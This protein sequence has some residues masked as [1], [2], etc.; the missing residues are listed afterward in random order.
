[1]IPRPS[2]DK[3]RRW[4]LAGLLAGAA[5]AALANAPSAS[6]RP[7]LRPGAARTPVAEDPLAGL[8]PRPRP[9]P[10]KPP[11]AAEIIAEARLG[12]R[13]D[14]A[15]VVADADSGVVLE[16]LSPDL[17]LPPASVNKTITALYALDTLGAGHRFRTRVIA[18]GPMENG[19]LDGDLVLA[20]SG[21][22]TLDTDG[23]ADLAGQVKA[24]GLREIT[25]RFL[26]WDGSLPTIP[27]IDPTQPDHVSYNPGVSGLNLNY[28]RVHFTWRPAGSRWEVFM[29][30]RTGSY[31]PDVAMARMEVVS[32]SLPIYTYESGAGVDRWT[33]AS[34][35]LGTGGTRWLPVKHPSE[36]TAEVFATFARSNGIVL[37]APERASAAPSGLAL[38]EVTSADLRT[39][40]RD[41]LK[42]S[43]NLTAEAVGL[44]ATARLRAAVPESLADSAAAMADWLAS[45]IGGPA[46]VLFDHSG[47]SDRTRITAADLVRMLVRLGPEED[48]GPILK[49]I[50]LRDANYR[51][52]E[53]HPTAVAAKTG[54]LNFV[55]ALAGYATLRG[56]RTV[57][58]AILT[59][60]TE[61]RATIPREDRESPSGAA[62]WARR[63][64]ILQHRLIDRW[65]ALY[66]RS[67]DLPAAAMESPAQGGGPAVSASTMN[68]I[69]R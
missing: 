67:A 23:L 52:I 1:M 26:V 65:S 39:V 20:G 49:D 14:V 25:G 55:S 33:V 41:M 69:V 51:V 24:A 31:R 3:T 38:G 42:Y 7:R 10:P 29:D 16:Q 57:A 30:A 34:G 21:D 60:D 53:G 32:R 28:N 63:S 43:T 54:T 5:D 56:N 66:Y 27:A 61:R 35:A 36:Y 8:R 64:R 11:E 9:E 68:Q 13:A 59:G 46:P 47:L 22:P 50:P 18:T 45:R 15:Y 62:P 6:L 37:P 40:L 12:A 48:L 4:L 44:A 58:F 19:R 2:P 17:A